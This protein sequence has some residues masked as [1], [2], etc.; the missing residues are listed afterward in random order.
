MRL[1]HLTSPLTH[2][3]DVSLAQKQLAGSNVFGVNFQPGRV[4]GQFGEATG[5][6]C[7]RA[8]SYLGYPPS[9]ILPSYGAELADYLSG[10]RLPLYHRWQ[11]SHAPKALGERALAQARIHL[12]EKESPAGSNKQPFGAWYG[13]NGVPWCAIFASYCYAHVGSKTFS[14]GRFYAYVPFIV[15][16]ARAGRNGLS[17]TR[18][19]QPGD[20]ACYDWERNGIADHV[21]LFEHWTDMP[22]STFAAVEGNTALS[23]DS[24]GGQVMQRT[25]KASQVQAFVRVAR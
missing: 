6:A 24:N 22:R 23:N 20:L 16:D 25:R 17:V 12:G 19:P 1:L 14:A 3:E 4:D 2:G 21:G 5:A 11:Q 18:D 8:K 15:N 10:T 13:M 9:K 7:I